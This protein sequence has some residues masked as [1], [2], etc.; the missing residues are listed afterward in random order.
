MTRR[1]PT[2]TATIAAA[3]VLASCGSGGPAG[4]TEKGDL[5]LVTAFYPLEFATQQVVKGVDGVTVETLTAPGVDAHDVELTPRQVGAV[6]EADLVVYSAGMQAAVDEAV[7]EQAPAHS[8]NTADVVDLV[9]R[10]GQGHADVEGQEH[11]EDA[12]AHNDHGGDNGHEGHDHGPLD[13][14][15]WLDPMRYAAATT[16]IAEELAVVDPDH[17]ETYRAN[18][19]AFTAELNTLDAEFAEGLADCAQDTLVTTH[20]A[21]GYLTD[22]YGLHQIGITGITPD[23]EASPARMA[24][25]IH[26][27]EELGV[28]AVYAESAIGGALA[29]VIAQETGAQVLV[30]DP[31]EGI[32]Q[33]SAGSDYLEVMHANL[34]ALE[35]GQECA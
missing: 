12:Q 9:D 26:Q 32:N 30:L 10:S 24:E 18:A 23:A 31:V 28:P 5:H 16:A 7:A 14:H 20:E 22:R 13:P 27:V 8:L 17:A 4:G 3:L 34:K 6:S 25:I 29:E 2:L 15:F 35:Q 33:D 11:Q 19:E 21:F 1:L